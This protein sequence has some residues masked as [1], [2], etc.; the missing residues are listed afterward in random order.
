MSSP[1]D[2]QSIAAVLL[3]S[4]TASP[5]HR[6][7]LESQVVAFFQPLTHSLARR[8]GHRGVEQ[9]DLQQIADLAMLKAMRRYD[10]QAGDL[11]GYVAATV[12][13]EI[14]RY[15]RDHSWTVRPP[16]QIQDLQSRVVDAL[17]DVHDDL[18]DRPRTVVVAERLGV[19]RAVVT[20]VLLARGGFRALSL[21]WSAEPGGPR[22]ADQVVD[23]DDPHLET[24]RHLF[25]TYVC[26]GLDDD[27]RALLHLRF[28]EELSQTQIAS[29]LHSSQK[30]VSRSLER[31]LSSLR[32]RALSDAA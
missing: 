25:V 26:A 31:I 19:D 4:R 17:A 1:H 2:D 13:G 21:E 23:A 9:D 8:Y 12:L 24:E 27:E 20:E 22:L 30:Q 14:K 16:R 7:R 6:Q 32:Q 11:R 15:F 3:T 28:V 18:S 10:P 29:R 5:I